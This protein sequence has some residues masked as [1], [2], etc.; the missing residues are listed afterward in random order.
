MLMDGYGRNIEP[1][2]MLLASANMEAMPLVQ[3]KADE[4][5]K[6]VEVWLEVPAFLRKDANSLALTAELHASSRHWRWLAANF[7]NRPAVVWPIEVGKSGQLWLVV[8]EA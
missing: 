7:V 3:S 8:G 6:I 5:Q 1:W 4:H 2:L